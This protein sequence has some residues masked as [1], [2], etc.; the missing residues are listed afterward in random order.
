MRSSRRDVF[1]SLFAAPALI[2]LEAVGIATPEARTIEKAEKKNTEEARLL[3]ISKEYT[4]LEVILDKILDGIETIAEE[5]EKE[6]EI[7]ALQGKQKELWDEAAK[8]PATTL[9]MVSAKAKMFV[10]FDRGNLLSKIDG[11]HWDNQMLA[12]IIS[13]LVKTEPDHTVLRLCPTLE[14]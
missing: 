11:P 3:E 6:P 5:E 13:D 10:A 2:G 9:K 8:I 1:S 7:K 4:K 12:T 14:S